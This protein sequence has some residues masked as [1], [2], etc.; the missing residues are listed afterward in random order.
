MAE[1][2]D[3]EEGLGGGVSRDEL[4]K[5]DD[6][7]LVGDLAD[8]KKSFDSS[9]RLTVDVPIEGWLGVHTLFKL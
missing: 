4:R 6:D 1:R 5:V 8:I 9:G 7:F 2:V 3:G